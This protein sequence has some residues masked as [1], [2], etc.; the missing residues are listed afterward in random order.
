[1]KIY[2]GFVGA[3]SSLNQRDWVAHPTILSGDLGSPA[4]EYPPDNAYHVVTAVGVNGAA[5]DGFT[6]RRR[7]QWTHWVVGA[8]CCA[9]GSREV[10]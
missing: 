5:V 2:G 6:D 10:A 7:L 1:M 4:N 8:G 3:E 9:C